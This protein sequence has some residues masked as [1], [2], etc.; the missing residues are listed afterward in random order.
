MFL[1]ALLRPLN[2]YDTPTH[3]GLQ[4]FHLAENFA[5]W[6]T[7]MKSRNFSLMVLKQITASFKEHMSTRKKEVLFGLLCSSICLTMTSGIYP[8]IFW[9]VVI[10]LLLGLTMAT[11]I[12]LISPLNEKER[13]KQPLFIK[14]VLRSKEKNGWIVFFVFLTLVAIDIAFSSLLPRSDITRYIVGR[15]Y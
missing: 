14:L 10:S 4:I 11:G 3:S 15:F 1:L 8:T 2:N 9:T 5:L 7:H 13:I 6:Y 12:S